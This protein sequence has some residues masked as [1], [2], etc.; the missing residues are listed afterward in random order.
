MIRSAQPT[1]GKACGLLVE[2]WLS[3][4]DYGDLLVSRSRILANVQHVISDASGHVLV[5]ET[6]NGLIDGCV[7][8]ATVDMLCFERKTA[9]VVFWYAE[10]PRTGY[11]MLRQA[12]SWVDGRRVIKSVGM[13]ADF[14]MDPRVC[15]L[16]ER[17]GL[18]RRGPVFARY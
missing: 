8:L 4:I 1:D 16:I 9:C 12:L 10:T 15:K 7:A 11:K 6:P 3:T 17:A 5:H 14:G 2:R 13:S 18:K